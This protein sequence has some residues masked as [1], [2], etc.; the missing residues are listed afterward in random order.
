MDG[1]N[2]REQQDDPGTPDRIA[3]KIRHAILHSQPV[4]PRDDQETF[5]LAP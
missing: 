3:V 5:D 1:G 2:A 4:K